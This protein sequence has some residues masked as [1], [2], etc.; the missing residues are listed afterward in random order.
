MVEIV[1][2]VI[3]C[4]GKEQRLPPDKGALSCG[5]RT[6]DIN[7]NTRREL[8]IYLLYI[9]RTVGQCTD[10]FLLYAVVRGTRI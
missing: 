10:I 8:R 6:K 9:T 2:D 4:E 5:Q 1:I 3:A 7:I